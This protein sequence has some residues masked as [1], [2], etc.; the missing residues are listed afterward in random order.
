MWLAQAGA[1]TPAKK[2]L[3]H[4]TRNI[5]NHYPPPLPPQICFLADLADLAKHVPSAMTCQKLSSLRFYLECTTKWPCGHGGGHGHVAALRERQKAF[6]VQLQ[7]ASLPVAPLPPSWILKIKGQV[8]GWDSG[9]HVFKAPG[10][11]PVA[12]VEGPLLVEGEEVTAA[13]RVVTASDTH[14]AVQ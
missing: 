14:S 10:C 2:C 3:P 1:K 11:S 6:S 7:Q 8:E 12:C 4:A 9:F 13:R 5:L